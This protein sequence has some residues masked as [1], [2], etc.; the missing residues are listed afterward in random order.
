MASYKFIRL[1]P[2]CMKLGGVSTTTVWRRVNDG[3]LPK[4]TTIGGLKVWDEAEIDE[5]IE[6]RLAERGRDEAA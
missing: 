3:T 4:P 6:T 2:L 5:F 1:N